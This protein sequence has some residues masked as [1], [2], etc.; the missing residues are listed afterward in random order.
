MKHKA[1]TYVFDLVAKRNNACF[2]IAA[3]AYTEAEA[4]AA[5]VAYYGK[6]FSVCDKAKEISSL[7]EPPAEK[8]LLIEALNFPSSPISPRE[9]RDYI[10][11]LKDSKFVPLKKWIKP[12]DEE[13]AKNEQTSME[14]GLS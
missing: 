3:T 8:E 1:S 7:E 2:D 6:N 12:T 10:N 11:G 5:I 4:R 14:D 13:L 9:V